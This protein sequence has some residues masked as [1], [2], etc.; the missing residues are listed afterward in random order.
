MKKTL[1]AL[2]VINSV[3]VP[4]VFAQEEKT[5]DNYVERIRILGTSDKLRT[6]GGAASLISETELEKFEFDDISRVLS[7][8]P[9]VNIREEDGY[10]LRPNIG[11]RGATTERSKKISLLE[12]GVLITPAPYSAPAAYYFPMVSRMAAVEVF[13]GPSAIKYGPNTVSGAL[14]LVT[15]EIPEELD[16]GIDVSYGSDNYTKLHGFHG[17]T[18]GNLGYVVEGLFV[19]ADGFKQL[20]GE[21]I[22]G[23]DTGFDKTDFMAK[24]KYDF[25]DGNG[26]HFIEFKASVADETSNETYLGLTDEDFNANPNRRYAGSQ[27]DQMDWDHSTLQLTHFIQL[28]NVDITT[29]AYRHDFERAWQKINGFGPTAPNL[30]TILLDP[31]DSNN[32]YY[33]NV[34]TGQEDGDI[35]VGTNDREYFSQGIQTD[36]GFDLKLLGLKHDIEVGLRYH[37]DEIQRDHFEEDYSMT[38]GQMSY[39]GNKRFTTVNTEETDAI[40]VYLQDTVTIDALTLTAGV[41]GEFIESRYEDRGEGKEGVWLEKDS[42]I[43]LPSVSAF[44]QLDKNYGVFAGVHQ[45]YI[46]SSP[47]QDNANTDSEKSLNYELGYRYADGNLNA[48]VVGFFNDYENLKETCTFSTSS[49]CDLDTEFD[50]GD[51]EVYGIE[52]NINHTIKLTNSI[53]LPWSVTYTYTESE[54]KNSFESDFPQWGVIEA[55]DALPYMPENQVA[56]EVGLA[57]D[58]W[59]VSLLAKYTDEMLERSGGYIESE[60]PPELTGY[61]VDSQL[62]L[63]IA[64]NYQF[65]EQH[66][67][68]G[69]IDN[70]TDEQEVVSRRPYGARPGKPL[71]AMIGYKYRF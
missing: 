14:N 52:A 35:V 37:Q 24:V 20:D 5:N 30:L 7:K 57:G 17:E 69:K 39:L 38:S 31:S 58:S 8:V 21:G 32:E 4:T 11:F 42:D 44:Y 29:R 22:E 53:D 36:I 68:Y 28:D 10:G 16:I 13:K 6:Q 46:P 51:V 12:D 55:G 23:D 71:S 2:A 34:L 59:S 26:N 54:F 19:K 67:I 40:S 64:A 70:L 18:T 60:Q 49:N 1:I 45:G 43:W 27:Q 66:T 33:Y 61:T 47:Q 56:I 15:R 3:T 48:E 65:A 50:G 25:S 62:V 9:G 63:D 41:R